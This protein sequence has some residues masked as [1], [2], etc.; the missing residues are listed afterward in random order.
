[1]GRGRVV[2]AGGR[3]TE[4]EREGRRVSPGSL[5]GERRVES[6]AMELRPYQE[7]CLER[8]LAAYRAGRRRL[9]VSLPTGT[10]KTV[11]F[12]QFPRFFRMRRRLLVLA[13]RGELLE[14]AREKFLATDPSLSVGIEQAGRRAEDAQV[15]VAS[16]PSLKGRRLAGFDPDDYYLVVVDEAHHAVAPSYRR[17]FEHFGVMDPGTSKLLV[18]FTA[19][20]RRGD[21]QSLDEVF[22]AIAY[23]KTLPEMIA[24]A[25]L[26]TVV[27]WR[28]STAVDLDGVKV[29]AGDFVES[30]LARTVNV[31]ARNDLLVRAYRK[32]A[33][34]RRCLVFCADV[35]HAKRVAEAFGEAGIPAAA[36][37]GAMAKDERR[38]V[39]AKFREG[40]VRVVT[41]CN[42][43]TEGFDEPLI[44]AVILARPT[45]SP[46]L[47][48]QMVGRG[49]RL[50]PGKPD[51][52]VV[53]VVDNSRRHALAGLNDL[54]G[55]PPDLDLA[56]ADALAFA[57]RLRD[58]ARRWP[59]LDLDAIGSSADLEGI[60][61][62]IDLFRFEPPDEIASATRFAWTAG[63]GGGYRLALPEMEEIVADPS[64]LGGFVVERRGRGGAVIEA[65]GRHP[66]P[67][68]AVRVA[69]RYV[70]KELPDRVTVLR[71]DAAWR[72]RAP[73]EKQ[74]E[75]LRA[76]GV[77]IPD[78]LTRGRASWMLAHLLGG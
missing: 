65:L 26:A 3:R 27:G 73:S 29:R 22:E 23:R 34:T 1:M 18:G 28:V 71:R 74:L 77:P 48:A 38:D 66:D 9:L 61:K 12:A 37:W 78:G 57:D 40:A 33:P 68:A 7:E 17:I 76:K 25:Y 45:K 4:E 58:A 21:R 52:L 43:L 62:R 35:A 59:W 24:S 16:V 2:G 54:F 46:L 75:I 30:Q 5:F 69:D 19:T 41:N 44:G 13:H 51:V 60:A 10:G 39:L 67:A 53:D 11:V 50:A 72:D 63:S 70:R 47:Y 56:G 15:V 32:L 42:V 8:L 49:T 6:A 55:L 20:P 36:V 31:T 64:L 14:Q